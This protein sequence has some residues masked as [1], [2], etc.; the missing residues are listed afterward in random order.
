MVYKINVNRMQEHLMTHQADEKVLGKPESNTVDY[1]IP[2]ETLSAV[3]QQDTYRKQLVEK[4]ENHPNKESFF[5]DFK[6][7]E[8]INE[9]IKESQDLIADM[10]N[11]EIFEL[12][13]ASSK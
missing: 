12:C 8:E 3:E 11:T 5:Q 4:F 10:N 13:E 6:Q 7:T 1:R 9:F 2:G